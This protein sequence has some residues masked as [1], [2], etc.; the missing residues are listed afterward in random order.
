V[1]DLIELGRFGR[2]FL[3]TFCIENRHIV[4]AYREGMEKKKFRKKASI[5][6]TASTAMIAATVWEALD[7][8]GA[9]LQDIAERLDVLSRAVQTMAEELEYGCEED[10]DEQRH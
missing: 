8:Y 9:M 10:E 4:H 1:I 2:Y 3:K 6:S 5:A 7:V